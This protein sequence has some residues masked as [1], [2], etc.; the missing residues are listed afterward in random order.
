MFVKNEKGRWYK[1]KY[2]EAEKLEGILAGIEV[3]QLAPSDYKVQKFLDCARH[4][5]HLR[6]LVTRVGCGIA[7]F[8]E[9]EIAPLFSDAVGLE[10]VCLPEGFVKVL[11]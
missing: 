1:M 5:T 8:K 2:D 11:K 3:F 4:E 10:N 9:K 7:G 6:F